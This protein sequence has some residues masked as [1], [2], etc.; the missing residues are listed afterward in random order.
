MSEPFRRDVDYYEILQVHPHA[1]ATVIRKVYHVLMLELRGHPDLGGEV[2]PAQLINE[3]FAVLSDPDRRREYDRFRAEVGIRSEAPGAARTAPSWSVGN[4]KVFDDLI[5][6]L[7]DAM[8][9]LSAW[10]PRRSAPPFCHG[11]VSALE[12]SVL[13]HKHAFRFTGSVQ[14]AQDRFGAGLDFRTYAQPQTDVRILV[15]AVGST[16]TA[17]LLTGPHEGLG[18]EGLV[19]AFAAE[20]SGGEADVQQ[21]ARL[22][23]AVTYLDAGDL[24]RRTR[25][26][27][28]WLAC[29]TRDVAHTG[30]V[31]A[32]YPL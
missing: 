18:Q 6:E 4:P 8:T 22:L 24:R 30:L 17:G 3:A 7:A 15:V 11:L 9:A 1:H 27:D 29:A 32:A 19:A 23:H 28:L 10:P 20:I 31:L 16:I 14:G 5:A 13:T 12:A 26:L 2:E 21:V 25:A